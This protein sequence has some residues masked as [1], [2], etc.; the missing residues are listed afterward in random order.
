MSWPR[1]S[2]RYRYTVF[3]ALIAVVVFG[4]AARLELPIQLFPDSDPPVVTVIT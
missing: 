3:A 4:V 2:L 1:L